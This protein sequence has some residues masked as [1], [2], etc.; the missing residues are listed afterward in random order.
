MVGTLHKQTTILF[1]RN[2]Y[3][4]ASVVLRMPD[5]RTS[6]TASYEQLTLISR[7][8]VC[9]AHFFLTATKLLLAIT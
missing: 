2:R 8:Q 9:A 6:R 1:G 5:V 3:L 4:G 7:D